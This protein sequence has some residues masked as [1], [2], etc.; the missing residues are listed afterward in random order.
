MVFHEI[1]GIN[2]DRENPEMLDHVFLAVSNI[3]FMKE[4]AHHV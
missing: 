1:E 2:Y 4:Q 3:P